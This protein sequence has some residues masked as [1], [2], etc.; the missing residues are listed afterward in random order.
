VE[1]VFY[2]GEFYLR[3]EPARADI[4]FDA[5]GGTVNGGEQYAVSLTVTTSGT[6]L[7]LY[8]PQREGYTFLGWN[9][10]PDGSG[11]APPPR[12]FSGGEIT[13]YAL[14]E[15]D[16]ILIPEEMTAQENAIIYAAFYYADGQLWQVTVPDG[17]LAALLIP[18]LPEPGMR[19]AIFCVDRVSYTPL[20]D[21]CT[22]PLP[23]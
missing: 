20:T 3:A 18:E 15:F 10:E 13:Y 7:A 9:S 22:G 11:D 19:Y 5:S 16:P 14:W 12:L 2:G 23:E 21:P 1:S 6:D 8:T 17:E 4:T